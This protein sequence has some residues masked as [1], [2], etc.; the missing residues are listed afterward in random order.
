MKKSNHENDNNRIE[1]KPSAA[2]SEKSAQSI[3]EKERKPSKLQI[4]EEPKNSN[5]ENANIEFELTSK[6][7]AFL[8]K[9]ASKLENLDVHFLSI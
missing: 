8:E 9:L 5:I 7:E 4:N 1:R 6:D 3:R 2:N